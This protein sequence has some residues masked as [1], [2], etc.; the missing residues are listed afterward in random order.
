MERSNLGKD[1]VDDLIMGYALPSGE[2][3]NILR[4]CL[5]L[6]GLSEGAP[7]FIVCR[8]CTSGIQT[9]VCDAVQK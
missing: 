7:G 3:A 4:V 9:I 2:V 6:A 5:L 8:M 1:L